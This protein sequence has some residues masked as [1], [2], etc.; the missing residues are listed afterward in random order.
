ME[1]HLKEQLFLVGGATSGFGKAVAEALVSEGAKIIATARGEESLKAFQALHPKQI[2]I[3]AVDITT[4][5]AVEKIADFIKGRQ[6]HGILINAGGPPA[7]TVL[8]SKIGD[9]DNAYK[10]VLRWKVKLLQSLIPSMIE[11]KY[12]RV[13]FVESAAVKQPME[14]LVLSNAFRLAVIGWMKTF[15]HEIASHGITMNALAPGY[16]DTNAIARIISK[17][18]EQSGIDKADI[19]QQ[20][21]KDTG[22][23]FLG[24]AEEFAALAVWLLSR[25][26]R[27]ITGQTITVAGDTI[28]GVMG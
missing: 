27:Y 13:L 19:K 1:L 18:S 26:S 10:S 17:K 11:N 12:G 14:N 28:R 5:E 2:E 23:G 15:S 20:I 25:Q 6:L 8:E 24:T 9:W 16:H 3:L 22:V 4:D 7:M 21:T